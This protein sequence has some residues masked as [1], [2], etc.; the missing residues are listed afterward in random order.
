M[1]KSYFATFV[2]NEFYYL[3][4]FETLANLLKNNKLPVLF[5]L[6]R[7]YSGRSARN[8]K[9]TLEIEENY[10]K[11]NAYDYNYLEADL[12]NYQTEFI[13]IASHAYKVYNIKHSHTVLMTHGI[14]TKS[15]YFKESNTYYDIQFCEGEYRKQ[16]LE[17]LFPDAKTKFINVGFAKL[18][19]AVNMQVHEKQ[20]LITAWGLCPNKKTILYSPTF[21]PSS[22]EKIKRDF[23]KDFS[24]YN[25][26]IK[27]HFF[28]YEL[29]K[30]KKQRQLFKYWNKFEN[31]Y[32]AT[33]KDFNLVPFMAVADVMITD[34]SSAMFEFIALDK[35]VICYREVKLRLSYRLF[36]KKLKRRIDPIIAQF[37]NSFTNAYSFDELKH[38]LADAL[39]KPNQLHTERLSLAHQLVGQTDGKVSDRILHHLLTHNK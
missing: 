4:I 15:G 31:T 16:K 3:Q 12:T 18:D 25:V 10:C 6:Q 21:Y 19:T 28:S 27:P 9:Q 2:L 5:L 30:Y 11:D 24:A 32:I 36:P 23:P 38:L 33:P 1:K 39:D 20:S 13:I 35:P 34:E 22:I 29:R 17:E 14:G 26:I 8:I 37:K 7:E